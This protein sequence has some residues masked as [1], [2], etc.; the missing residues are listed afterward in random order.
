MDLREEMLYPSIAKK[1]SFADE[2]V[3]SFIDDVAD[4][5]IRTTVLSAVPNDAGSSCESTFAGVQ[6]VL[7]QGPSHLDVRAY[8]RLHGR[9]STLFNNSLG[10]GC[11]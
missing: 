4:L 2:T 9:N 1:S 7:P 8:V 10:G 6:G 11:K 5:A 3:D